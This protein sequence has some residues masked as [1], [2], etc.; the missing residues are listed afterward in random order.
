MEPRD[1][2]SSVT[3][4]ETRQLDRQIGTLPSADNQDVVRRSSAQPQARDVTDDDVI[5]GDDDVRVTWVDDWLRQLVDVSSTLSRYITLEYFND[6]AA[7]TKAMAF[8]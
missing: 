6:G 2:R 3:D 1:P 7:L 8:W 5:A 4:A